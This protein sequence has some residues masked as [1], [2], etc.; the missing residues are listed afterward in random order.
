MEAVQEAITALDGMERCRML[1]THDCFA[2]YSDD[3]KENCIGELR[4]MADVEG[5]V[6]DY[7]AYLEGQ[8]AKYEEANKEQWRD[9]TPDEYAND[10]QILF[11]K[12][13]DT[14]ETEGEPKHIGA[15][16]LMFAFMQV[17]NIGKNFQQKGEHWLRPAF[18][19]FEVEPWE[20]MRRLMQEGKRDLTEDECDL[21]FGW[22]HN[23]ARHRHLLRLKNEPLWQQKFLKEIA[24]DYGDWSFFIRE[25]VV[26]EAAEHCGLTKDQ[27]RDYLEKH[28]KHQNDNNSSETARAAAGTER[29]DG[30]E[31]ARSPLDGAQAALI[32]RVMAMP[33]ELADAKACGITAGDFV[34]PYKTIWEILAR[35]HRLS[36]PRIPEKYTK[37]AAALGHEPPVGALYPA[38][39]LA[40]KLKAL[41]AQAAR[42]A[43]I[44]NALRTS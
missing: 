24:K 15:Q 2:H 14:P 13:W 41:N 19:R 37:L 7:N 22:E 27:V 28:C 3:W 8:I 31:S 44:T 40:R 11:Q 17:G 18:L 26:K 21:L 9:K 33:A 12:L 4:V 30:S 6:D 43:A 36:D 16:L 42:K 1:L 20:M 23:C 25:Q 10:L 39:E 29:A 34:E 35:G 5:W 38:P 32:A